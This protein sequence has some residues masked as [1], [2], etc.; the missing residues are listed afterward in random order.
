MKLLMKKLKYRQKSLEN[1]EDRID[2]HS[3]AEKAHGVEDREDAEINERAIFPFEAKEKERRYGEADD[4]QEN[5]DADIEQVPTEFRG[6]QG[7][8][9]QRAKK[10]RQHGHR[11]YAN[12][13]ARQRR[14]CASLRAKEE[15]SWRPSR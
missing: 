11:L 13:E 12:S 8:R 14:K 2:E 5:A 4:Q 7:D 1:I 3:I 10:K 9:L 15:R 6:R